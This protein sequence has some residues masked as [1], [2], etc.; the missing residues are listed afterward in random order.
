MLFQIKKVGDT[1]ESPDGEPFTVGGPNGVAEFDG[2]GFNH[3]QKT[4]FADIGLGLST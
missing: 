2:A 3:L 1:G 4:R